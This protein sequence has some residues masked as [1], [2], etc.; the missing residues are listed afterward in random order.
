MKKAIMFIIMCCFLVA[1]VFA[2]SPEFS[3]PQLV[4]K[5]LLVT[6]G[7]SVP[8][9]LYNG[10]EYLWSDMVVSASSSLGTM[11]RGLLEP[12]SFATVY[13]DIP[14]VYLLQADTL[15]IA[16]SYEDEVLD[17]KSLPVV[18]L[19]PAALVVADTV[20]PDPELAVFVDASQFNQSL[21]GVQVEAV[22]LDS[23][24]NEVFFDWYGP[25]YLGA[26]EEFVWRTSLPVRYL[27]AGS[28]TIRST[29]YEG[30]NFLTESYSSF[31]YE[32]EEEVY[33]PVLLL[34]ISLFLLLLIYLVVDMVFHGRK[35]QHSL[36]HMRK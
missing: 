7:E 35:I 19:W 3:S 27:S 23:H 17:K 6:P 36:E 9:E 8:V 18:V 13:V 16:L 20:N 26:D 21:G 25:F 1:S 4:N 34:V 14:L 5:P 11:Y 33:G 28:Y 24:G 29:F 2:L 30:D 12:D 31:V 10:G 22:I 15:P 32:D